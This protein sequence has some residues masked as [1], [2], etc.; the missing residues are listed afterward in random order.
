ML[1]LKIEN[2]KLKMYVVGIARKPQKP[3]KPQKTLVP[4]KNKVTNL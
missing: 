4:L 3:Q 1:G 2:E